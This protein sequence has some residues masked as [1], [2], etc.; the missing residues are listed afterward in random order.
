MTTP[1]GLLGSL[2]GKEAWQ[3]LEVTHVEL[4]SYLAISGEEGTLYI[5]RAAARKSS[6]GRPFLP[7]QLL[8]V[9]ARQG[10]EILIGSYWL[11]THTGQETEG[12]AFLDDELR[13]V[14]RVASHQEELHE[15]VI[16]TLSVVV[17]L[18]ESGE[19]A[20]RRIIHDHVEL[21]SLR[22]KEGGEKFCK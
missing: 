3:A 21:R 22:K 10:L 16:A 20:F 17:R 12:V 13:A 7:P 15:R 1:A 4:A 9:K 8:R 11:E 5:E 19:G 2:V 18:E 6:V 14:W